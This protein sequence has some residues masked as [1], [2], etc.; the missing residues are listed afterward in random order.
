MGRLQGRHDVVANTIYAL[1]SGQGR[2]GVAVVRLSGPLA[3]DALDAIAGPRPSPRHAVLR[4]LRDPVSAEMID[5]GL[6][7][8]FPSPRSFTGEDAAEVHVHGGR[9]IIL[10]LMGVLGAMP[11]LR[12]AE[13]GEFTRRAFVNGKMD[14]TEV[15]GLSELIAADTE[16]QRRFA[17]RAATGEHGRLYESWRQTLLKAMANLEAMIDFADQDD[18]P[19]DTRRAADDEVVVLERTLKTHLDGQVRGE[20]LSEGVL[21]VIAGPPNV[22]KSTLLNALAGRDVAIVAP[23]P[24][25][26]RDVIE[27]ALDLGGFPVRAVDTA[28]LRNDGAG[29]IEQEGMRRARRQIEDADLVLWLRTSESPPPSVDLGGRVVWEVWTKADL[30]GRT[31]EGPRQISAQTGYGVEVLLADL[32]RFAADTIGMETERPAVA[33][34]RHRQLLAETLVCVERAR[35]MWWTAPVE[36]VAEELRCAAQLMGRV[37]GRVDVE[38]LLEHVFRTFCIGK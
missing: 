1:S 37:T 36:V 11:G 28:G 34:E 27:V 3:G 6:V 19:V 5:R 30:G 29:P 32:E 22:G 14:L 15:E 17:V 38:D 7:L 10:R 9:A 31:V 8:W 26:T 2:A 24:G 35:G 12:A 20:R 13:P 16:V 18:V 21:V 33:R 25:T 4:T 23:E